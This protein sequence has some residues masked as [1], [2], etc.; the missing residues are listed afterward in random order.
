MEK[1]MIKYMHCARV[2]F[3]DMIEVML[4]VTVVVTR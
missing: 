1:Q 4:L 3:N 2:G